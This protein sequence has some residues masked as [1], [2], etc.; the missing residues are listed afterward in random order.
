MGNFWTNRSH[1]VSKDETEGE[2]RI[3]V[4]TWIAFFSKTSRVKRAGWANVS[5]ALFT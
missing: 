4:V 2:G 1:Y 5:N 3:Q